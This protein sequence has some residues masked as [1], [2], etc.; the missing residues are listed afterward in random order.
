MGGLNHPGG[1]VYVRVKKK[2]Y[3]GVNRQGVN[4]KRSE[5]YGI[6]YGVLGGLK[7]ILKGILRRVLGGS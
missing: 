6:S 2:L 4:H 7:G 5:P 3:K 1:E